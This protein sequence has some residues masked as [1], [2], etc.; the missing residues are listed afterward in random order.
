[1]S[2][3]YDLALRV[4]EDSSHP[5]HHM[6]AVVAR[7]G[8]VLSVATNGRRERQH[9]EARALRA[10]KDAHGATVYVAREGGRASRPCPRCMQE[11]RLAGVQKVYWADWQGNLNEERI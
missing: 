6:A 9:A 4:T 3:W 1:M 2:R 11:L 5:K 7:G 10:C 8:V